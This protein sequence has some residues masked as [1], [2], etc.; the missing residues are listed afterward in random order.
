MGI[1]ETALDNA[2]ETLSGWY[3]RF[4]ELLPNIIVAIIIVAAATIIAIY[5]KRYTR[6]ALGRVS[7]NRSLNKFISILAFIGVVLLGG[8]IALSILHLQKVV[9][10]LLAGVGVV[11]IALG[12][13]FQDAFSNLISGIALAL[14]KDYPFQVDDLIETNGFMGYVKDIHL[15]STEITTLQGQSVILP[16]KN[17]FEKP[18]T[19]YTMQKQRRIDLGVGISYGDDL[20]K[21]QRIATAAVEKNVDGILKKKGITAYYS[22]F[23]NSSID[24]VLRFWVE[25][26]TQMEFLKQQSDAIIAVKK[27]FDKHDVTIPFPI[28]TLDF[29]IKGGKPLDN[30]LK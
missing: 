22:G 8:I 7:D 23:G 16:N 13:A 2:T 19:N 21:V 28:R 11:G 1:I 24:F 20:E 12:F 10:S 30:V 4:S 27:A 14:K 17:I 15:R 6:K 26:K 5:V 18:L 25:A 3:T 29:G 9:I